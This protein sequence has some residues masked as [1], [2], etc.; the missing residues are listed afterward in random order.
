MQRVLE[1]ELMNNE[2]Q[3][4]AYAN[5]DFSEPH[6]LFI[7]QF[8]TVF[9][10]Q[11][12]R[13]KVLDL[14]CGPADI[15]IRFARA[16]PD[17]RIDGVDGAA[18]MLEQ[19]KLAVQRAQLTERINFIQDCLPNL[20]LPQAYYHVIMSNSLL[21]H[22]HKPEVL[23]RC[24]KQ[25]GRPGCLVFIMDLRR[26]DSAATARKLVQLHAAGE[27]EILQQDFY[28]SLRAAFSPAEIMI[29]LE[30]SGLPHLQL[31]L[32]SDRHLVVFGQC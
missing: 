2:T 4:L 26:P 13:G 10:G 28:N 1:P 24:I 29:Q 27:P 3:V 16:F 9:A 11:P 21:H 6:S 14:G 18:R 15:S 20:K 7:T 8:Q 31:E 12:V 5:A 25:L 22:L 32:V 30:N 23:W 17:C 19:A